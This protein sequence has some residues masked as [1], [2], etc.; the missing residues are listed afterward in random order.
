MNKPISY[1]YGENDVSTVM[2][3]IVGD[4]GEMNNLILTEVPEKETLSF[5]EKYNEFCDMICCVFDVTE[6]STFKWLKEIINHIE[7]GKKVLLIGTKTD[8]LPIVLFN[9]L[10]LSIAF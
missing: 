10:L 4:N 8:L 3:M 5:L 9:T 6:P 2:N 1:S 7:N